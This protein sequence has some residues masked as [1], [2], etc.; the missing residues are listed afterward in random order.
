MLYAIA[1]EQIINYY[2]YYYY[3][4][5]NVSYVLTFFKFFNDFKYC[6]FNMKRLHK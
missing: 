2:Y 6:V 5:Y 4:Y 1:M 3:Y